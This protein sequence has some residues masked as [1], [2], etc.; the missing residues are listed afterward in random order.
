MKIIS[1]SH[2]ETEVKQRSECAALGKARKNILFEIIKKMFINFGPMLKK[3]R[4]SDELLLHITL[5]L[6]MIIHLKK[7]PQI[8]AYL[9]HLADSEIDRQT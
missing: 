8:A 9:P 6:Y 3:V 4:C 2:I 1:L 5:S 7:T